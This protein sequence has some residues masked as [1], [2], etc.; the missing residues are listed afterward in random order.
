MNGGQR[1]A[2]RL[3]PQP[4]WFPTFLLLALALV[5]P[6]RAATDFN[7]AIARFRQTAEAMIADGRMTGASVA[8]IAGPEL[9]YV[10]GFGLADKRRSRPATADTVYRVGSI[11]KLF[12][13]VSV[14]Q[15]AEQGRV[16][17]DAP[18]ARYAPGFSYVNPFPEDAP[19]TLRQLMCHRSGLIRESPAGNYFDP[20]EPGTQATALSLRDTVLVHRPGTVTKYSNSGVTVEGYA[21]EAVSGQSFRDYQREHV[22]GRLG[23]NDSDWRLTRELRGRLAKGYLA[24]ARPDGSFREIEAPQFEFGILPAGNLYSTVGDLAR[25]ALCLFNEGRTGSGPMLRPETLR[26][27]FTVQ[28]SGET[29]GFGLGFSLQTH[30]GFRTV[31]HSGAV[32]GFSSWFVAVPEHQLA[33]VV[34][35]NDDIVNAGRTLMMR[36]LDLLLEAKLGM[37]LPAVPAPVTLPAEALVKCAGEFESASYWASLQVTGDTLRGSFS[38]QAVELRPVSAERFLAY[39]RTV[40]AGEVAFERDAAGE[41]TGFRALG[42]RFSR[43]PAGRVKPVPE[44]WRRFLGSYG[45]DFI[46]LIVSERHGRLYAMTE[47]MYDYRL[48]PLNQTVFQMPPGLYVDEQLVFHLDARGRAHAVSL[49][50]IPLKRRR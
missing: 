6:G 19:V 40:D 16:D 48:T 30:R 21:V 22:L 14:M 31:G 35:N 38:G 46:P 4:N 28:L 2:L 13:A 26:E 17:L 7:P 10:D 49:A 36:G 47:N 45:P 18:V 50:N 11:S 24:V 8:L 37:P 43:V 27:M 33:V 29:N 20:A 15:L 9:I 25:F 12:A 34:L 1:L 42:Q 23:M 41:V 32:Y 5:L 3:F 44:E 39:G